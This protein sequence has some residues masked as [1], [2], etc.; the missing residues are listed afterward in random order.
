[1][2][3]KQ[4]RSRCTAVLP[5]KWITIQRLLPA[6]KPQACRLRLC[7]LGGGDD[8]LPFLLKLPTSDVRLILP[9]YGHLVPRIH[10]NTMVVRGIH[11]R[12]DHT[13]W[14]LLDIMVSAGSGRC[15]L[16]S[17]LRLAI[18]YLYIVFSPGGSRAII[19]TN[20]VFQTRSFEQGKPRCH[21]AR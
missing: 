5:V 13:L 6:L 7:F 15:R 8:S 1:M 17:L 10:D 19:Q 4:L 21:P 18:G 20:V 2:K 16:S 9:G 12:V 11:A 3:V 14:T